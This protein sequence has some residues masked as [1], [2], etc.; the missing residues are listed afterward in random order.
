M[1]VCVYVDCEKVGSLQKN[2]SVAKSHRALCICWIIHFLHIDRCETCRWW[3]QLYSA[4]EAAGFTV[5]TPSSSSLNPLP[6][7][8]YMCT[9]LC[10]CHF[11]LHTPHHPACKKKGYKDCKWTSIYAKCIPPESHR[12]FVV[13]SVLFKGAASENHQLDAQCF[14]GQTHSKETLKLFYAIL[15]FQVCVHFQKCLP[16]FVGF[17]DGHSDGWGQ[18]EIPIEWWC[19]QM[20]LSSVMGALRGVSKSG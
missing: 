4:Q 5:V 8:L 9:P 14:D 16:F 6:M 18:T 15:W 2:E 1:F 10:A 17:G 7:F 20:M 13:S 11:H 12:R 19:L 3:K